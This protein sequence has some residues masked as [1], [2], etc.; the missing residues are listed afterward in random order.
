MSQP[1]SIEYAPEALEHLAQIEKKYYSLIESSIFEQLS[2]QPELQTR[3]RK[4][5]RQPS[6]FGAAW[7][8]RFGPRNRFRVLYTVDR[9]TMIVR[10][11]AIGEKLR[12][13]LLFGGEEFQP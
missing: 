13:R 4:P 11:A 9:D 1:F 12:N 8:C 6:S 2:A 3:N 7:E 10:I 5:L